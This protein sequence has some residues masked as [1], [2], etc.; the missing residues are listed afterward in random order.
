MIVA[1]ATPSACLANA[2]RYKL[3]SNERGFY[4]AQLG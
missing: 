1:S 3:Q 4:F 2:R